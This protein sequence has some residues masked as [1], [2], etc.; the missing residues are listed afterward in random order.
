[1]DYNEQKDF[2]HFCQVS[3]FFYFLNYEHVTTHL[4]EI[5]KIQNKVTYSFTIHYN[6]FLSR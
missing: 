3:L 1:M 5:W 6:Y 2:F 4:Q